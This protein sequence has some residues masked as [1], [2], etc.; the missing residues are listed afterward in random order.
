MLAARLHGRGDLRVDHLPEPPAPPPGWVRLRIDACGICG[1][2]VEE[3]T[4]GPVLVPRTPLT[5]GHEAVGEVIEVG[6][7]V[8]LRVG[9]RVAVDGN[10][11]C[12]ECFWCARRE[13]QLCAKLASLGLMADGGLAEQMLAPA[14][15]CIPYGDHVPAEH[16]A[17]ADPLSVAD[18]AIRRARIT[19]GT[20]VGIVG[21][22][23]VGLLA[24]QVAR[25]AGAKTIVCVER[26]PHRRE[27]ALQLGADIAVAPHEAALGADELTAGVGLDVTIEVA[28]NAEAAASTVRLA[29]RGGRAVLLGVFDD[30]VPIDMIDFLFGEKEIIA[31]LSHVYDVDFVEAVRLI[32]SDRI[33][34]APLIT[35]RISLADV[36][37]EGFEPLVARGDE[38]LKVMVYP[39]GRPDLTS[40]GVA[41]EELG[42]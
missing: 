22:G 14:F 24:L 17:L 21:A 18:R 36:V 26:H 20:T 11:F 13:F 39:Q 9:T 3:L 33:D 8:E 31:S 2:D 40:A 27:L 29:R 30:V 37:T 23:A 25:A 19:P 4:A 34:V 38:H 15:M 16:P 10:M 32:D 41:S 12:G 35:D 7:G 5:L 42:R 1:T 6:A 28:G